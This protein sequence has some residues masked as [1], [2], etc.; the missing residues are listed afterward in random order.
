[1]TKNNRQNKLVCVLY[2]WIISNL[3]DLKQ[4]RKKKIEELNRVHASWSNDNS[5]ML[6][7]LR[8]IGA[9]EY[10]GATE[11]FCEEKH[12]HYKVLMMM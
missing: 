9:F 10:A 8:A 7:I 4:E 6:V 1:M 11:Q 2:L 5:D 12:L 3:L